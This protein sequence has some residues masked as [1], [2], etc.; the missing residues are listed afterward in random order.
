MDQSQI[1][2]IIPHRPP[3][4]LVDKIIELAPGRRAVGLTRVR[5]DDGCILAEWNG[6]RIMTGALVLEAMAQVGAVAVLSSSEH[7][8]KTTLLA[9]IENACFYREALPGEEIRIEAD[10]VKMKGRFGKRRCRATVGNDTVAEAVLLFILSDATGT[11]GD[12]CGY[13]TG[14]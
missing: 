9:G 12:A 11:E 1:E 2:A 8:G 3:F 6:K 14:S 7:R 4:L 5:N 13:G 10:I